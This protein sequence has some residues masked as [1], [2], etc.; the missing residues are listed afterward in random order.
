MEKMKGQYA[1]EL[2]KLGLVPT[3]DYQDA[4]LNRNSGCE[5]LVRAVVTIG[6]VPNVATLREEQQGEGPARFRLVTARGQTLEFHPRSVNRN[7]MKQVGR[8][9]IGYY[10][11]CR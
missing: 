11:I 10:C 1:L 4:A 7:V 3:S 9:C 6:L 5:A 8:I 2:H